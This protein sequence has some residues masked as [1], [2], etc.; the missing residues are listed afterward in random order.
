[1]LKTIFYVR[2]HFPPKI[3]R[4]LKC[5]QSSLEE[6]TNVSF[7]GK[8]S[9]RTLNIRKNPSKLDVPSTYKELC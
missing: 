8:G 6:I 1:M 5:S 9:G 3:L 4:S 2:D 7:K